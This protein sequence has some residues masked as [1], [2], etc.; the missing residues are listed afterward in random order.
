MFKNN[1]IYRLKDLEFLEKQLVAGKVVAKSLKILEDLV[2]EKTDKSLIE[3]DLLIESLIVENKCVPIFKGYKGFPNACCISVNNQLVHGIPTDYKLVDG[4]IIKF[5]LG[6]SY[7]GCI[8][9][10]AITCIYGEPKSNLHMKMIEGCR[11]CLKKGIEGIKIDNRIGS[12]GEIIFNVASS[13]GLKVIQS[14]G[15]HG[16]D[17]NEKGEGIL[18]SEPFINN[19]DSKNNGIRIQEGLVI[20]LEPMVTFGDIGT[21]VGE[22]GWS[23]YTKEVNAHFEHTIFIGKNGVNIITS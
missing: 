12:I 13:Y 16:I 7:E 17:I 23:V 3:L 8:A 5:D 14:Y 1:H 22:D 9:D 6:A 21:K 10:A 15:G 18:H 19:K 4:D 2:A 20:C 11:E